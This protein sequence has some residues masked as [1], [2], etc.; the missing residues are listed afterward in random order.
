MA[1][2][3]ADRRGGVGPELRTLKDKFG[4]KEFQQVVNNGKGEMPAFA[5][6]KE[7][8]VKNLYN[9][10][11]HSYRRWRQRFGGPTGPFK[12]YRACC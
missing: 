9:Y 2:H 6:L 5:S 1:C 12:I 8:D 4:I 10:I 11:N 7:E 3:G